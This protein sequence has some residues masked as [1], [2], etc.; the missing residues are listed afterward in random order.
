MADQKTIPEF[1]TD[2]EVI[3]N[4]DF[5]TYDRGT[6]ENP[7]QNPP[8]QSTRPT[9]SE[10][11]DSSQPHKPL[12]RVG[13][14]QLNEATDGTRTRNRHPSPRRRRRINTTQ[15]RRRRLPPSPPNSLAPPTHSTLTPTTTAS[16]TT[17]N[18]TPDWTQQTRIQMVMDLTT[19]KNTTPTQTR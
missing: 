5:A 7:F 3:E 14:T 18:W 2:V 1:D 13:K 19:A 17:P 16:T 4:S 10:F 15:R 12:F 11:S 8:P 6:A 9:L